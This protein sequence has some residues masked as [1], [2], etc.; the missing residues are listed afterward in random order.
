MF[1]ELVRPTEVLDFSWDEPFQ[2]RALR[3]SDAPEI[4]AF[5]LRVDHP[6]R[7]EYERGT[8]SG[9]TYYVTRLF[10]YHRHDRNFKLSLQVSTIVRLTRIPT[11]QLSRGGHLASP[12]TWCVGRDGFQDHRPEWL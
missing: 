10:D 8:L 4:G 5:L 1:R 6:L 9:A 12:D 11:C 2:V 3:E 7:P